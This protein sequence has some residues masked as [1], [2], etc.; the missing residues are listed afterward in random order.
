MASWS[1]NLNIHSAQVVLPTSDLNSTLEFFTQRLGFRLEMIMPAD[2]P[3]LAVVSGHGMSI[4]FESG[5]SDTAAFPRLRLH[6]NYEFLKGLED[7]EI[8]VPG[9]IR[10]EFV[11]GRPPIA[12]L[13]WNPEFIITRAGDEN[14]WTTGRAGMQYRD[15]IPGKLGGAVVASHIRIPDGGKT[16]DYVHYHRV[17]FQMIYCKAGWARLV[18]EDQGPPFIMNAGDC[19]LQPPEIRHRVLETS[20]G[21]EV[22]EIG[23]P[24]IHQT[25]ADHEMQLPT[26]KKQPDRLFSGQ[27]FLH[28]KAEDADWTADEVD[29]CEVWQTGIMDATEGLADVEVVRNLSADRAYFHGDSYNNIVLLYIL[30]GDGDLRIGETVRYQLSEGDCCSLP[31]Y[32]AFQVI[33]RKGFCM[34]IASLEEK[35]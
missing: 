26:S 5:Q 17:L 31:G 15:L 32:T 13:P 12:L 34:L 2:S 3:S 6:C 20:A 9:G 29:D 22:I 30:S 19:V 4:R 8:T 18:Y 28:D 33:G 10:I 1:N 27:Y 16:P 25:F 11:E 14:L 35:E 7:R 24:A 21:F 23:S